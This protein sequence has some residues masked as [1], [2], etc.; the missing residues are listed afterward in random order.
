MKKI[1]I[2]QVVPSFNIGGVEGLVLSYL[3]N[4]NKDRM[5]LFCI[6]LYERVD[7]SFTRK[8]EQLSLPVIYLNKRGPLSISFIRELRNKIREIEPTVIHTHMSALKY[9]IMA[10]GG[11]YRLFHTIHSE[12]IKDAGL[13]DRLLNKYLFKKYKVSVI[14]LHKRLAEDVKKYYSLSK[15]YVIKNGVDIQKFIEAESIRERLS[16]SKDEFVIV[17]VGRFHPAKNH[18]F[19]I[20]VFNE[21]LKIKEKSRLVLVGTGSLE[22]EIRELSSELDIMD[23]ILFLGDREDVA[24][25]LKSADIFLFPSIYEGFGI[26]VIEAEASGL[27]TIVSDKVPTEVCILENVKQLP[28]REELWVRET[29]SSFKKDKRDRLMVLRDYDIRKI[30][31]DLCDLYEGVI[32][33]KTI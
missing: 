9:V 20:R 5:E 23:K 25:V 15:T 24:A 33:E 14:A 28:L 4:Y 18:L 11:D 16:L 27:N 32:D 13:Y 31:E 12:I 7:T 3:S 21:I 26:A 8:I 6:S 1:R 22:T 2:L 17:N 29:L 30:M 19:L 10:G